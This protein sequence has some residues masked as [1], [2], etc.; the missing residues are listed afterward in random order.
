MVRRLVST[1]CFLSMVVMLGACSKST[2]ESSSSETTPSSTTVIETTTEETTTQASDT[3][4]TS[5]EDEVKERIESMKEESNMVLK[6]ND[7]TIKVEWEENESAAALKDL[8]SSA[9]ITIEMS[10]YGGFEQVGSLGTSLPRSDEQMTTS[11]GDIVLYSG[12]QIV[13]FYGSNSWSYTRLGKIQGM[14]E[15]KLTDLLG[16]ADVTISISL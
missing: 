5:S 1:I 11:A 9:P 6:I 3:T 15:A 10:K 7:Q 16:S 8:C 13:V 2:K 12:N 4:V 14:S